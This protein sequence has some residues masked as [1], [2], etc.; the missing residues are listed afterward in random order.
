MS[1]APLRL[2]WFLPTAG[3]GPYLSSQEGWRPAEIGYMQAIA[4]SAERLGFEGVLL[5]T[6]PSCLDGWTLT[7]ALAP[8]TRRLKYLVAL[9]PGVVAPA[10]AA[11]QAAALDR[12][13][14]GR[15]LLNIVTG[16]NPT[17][18]AQ[19]G[20]HLGHAER[21]RQTDEFLTVWRA[22]ASG[23][24]IRFDGAHYR[25]ES[26][27]GSPIP[28]SSSPIRRSTSAVPRTSAS[29]SPPVTSTTT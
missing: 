16:G 29:M 3:D 25:M 28:R 22:V 18:L 7:S 12:V 5:P 2:F 20:V 10:F 15:L 19:D 6:G 8:L 1:E 14:Q 11:R 9:R 17:E 21:Y 13:L 24:P 23:E 26:Q 4:Q 27:A